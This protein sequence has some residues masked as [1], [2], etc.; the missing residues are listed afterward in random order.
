MDRHL[1]PVSS[2][3]GGFGSPSS[4][5]LGVGDCA[6]Q[7]LFG[8]PQLTGTPSPNDVFDPNPLQVRAGTP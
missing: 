1:G 5:A 7:G 4:H 3:F 8:E 2:K 6:R